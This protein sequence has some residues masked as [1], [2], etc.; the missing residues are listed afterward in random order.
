MR[1]RYL[2]CQKG[3]EVAKMQLVPPFM[4]SDS[5]AVPRS[6]LTGSCPDQRFARFAEILP[7]WGLCAFGMFFTNPGDNF[8][9]HTE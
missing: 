6:V 8:L 9:K 1:S 2:G 5:E 3:A 7:G 4:K